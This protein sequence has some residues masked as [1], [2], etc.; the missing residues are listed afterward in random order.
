VPRE[1]VIADTKVT[2]NGKLM[3]VLATSTWALKD[4]DE[5]KKL[6]HDAAA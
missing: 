5:A 3:N 4:T 6:R 1:E 2:G